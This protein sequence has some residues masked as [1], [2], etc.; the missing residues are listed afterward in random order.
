MKE[1]EIV[2]ISTRVLERLCVMGN[3]VDGSLSCEKMIFPQKEN[4][5]EKEIRISEQELRFQFVEEFVK[6]SK[7]G[8]FYSV[9][10]P[11]E[12]KYSFGKKF[13]DIRVDEID[14][15]SALSDMMIYKREDGK[16]QRNLNI[17]FKHANVELAHIAKDILKLVNESQ[18][19]A[20]I[21]LLDNT[22]SGTLC[23]DTPRKDCEDN[24]IT[25]TGVLNKLEQ[26]FGK[27]VSNWKGEKN[28]QI[29]I[30]IMSL[31][32]RVLIYRTIPKPD[33]SKSVAIFC[34]KGICTDI[35]K[36]CT[37]WETVYI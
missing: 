29:T 10:T 15:Q 7:A 35:M 32:Q 17:E 27:F 2:E 30:V 3:E 4:N 34:K 12:S 22:D 36:T 8:Y 1:K 16:Y 5:G 24:D 19:G 21:H 13:C 6:R 11:T 37:D 25:G 9:E 23:N 18:N 26:S 33:L 31:K 20:F 28:K 14:G